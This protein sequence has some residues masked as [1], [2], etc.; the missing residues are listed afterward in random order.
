MDQTKQ[1]VTDYEKEVYADKVWAKLDDCRVH[2]PGE[3]MWGKKLPDGTVAINNDP[4]DHDYFWQDIVKV[5]SN[6][7]AG[8]VVHRRWQVKIWFKY[9]PAKTENKDI[10]R[11]KELLKAT[12]LIGHMSFFTTGLGYIYIKKPED[13]LK[14]FEDALANAN[15]NYITESKVHT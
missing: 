15:I 7:D 5:H 2:I 10:E 11:R 6:N 9:E 13:A 3:N 12:R 4:I 14:I 1:A 8:E